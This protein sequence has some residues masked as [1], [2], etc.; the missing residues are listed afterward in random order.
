MTNLGIAIKRQGFS[1]RLGHF[2]GRGCSDYTRA[3]NDC[4]WLLCHN[5]FLTSDIK[6]LLQAR[7][8]APAGS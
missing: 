7:I 1:S 4:I 6:L 8:T 5:L 2:K 3:D